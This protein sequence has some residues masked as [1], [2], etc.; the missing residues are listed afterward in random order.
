MNQQ[1]INEFK[2]GRKQ[3]Q[4]SKSITFSPRNYQ[5]GKSMSMPILPAPDQ[6]Q[7]T[8]MNNTARID[9]SDGFGNNMGG[10]VRSDS[11]SGMNGNGKKFNHDYL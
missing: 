11:G 3:L 4:I 2:T 8:F 10:N 6:T 5:D 9:L 7:T 1:Q